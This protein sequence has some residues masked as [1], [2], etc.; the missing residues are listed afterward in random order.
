[1]K[2]LAKNIDT[3]VVFKGA[4]KPMP[5]KFKFRDEHE[6]THEIIIGK[7]LNIEEKKTAGIR[8][9]NYLCESVISGI[10]K[11]Y[12]L[13]YILQDCKWQLYKM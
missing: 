7:I 8:T 10:E 12:E 1:M 3:I 9:Y 5:Y 13:K 6:N 4:K 11:Q 2:I